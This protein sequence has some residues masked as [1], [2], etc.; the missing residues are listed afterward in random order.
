MYCPHCKANYD[1]YSQTTDMFFAPK[2]CPKCG[3]FLNGKT[4][5]QMN[6][7]F[8]EKVTRYSNCIVEILENDQGDVSVGWYKTKETEEI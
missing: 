1:A 8:Y 2:Y 6:M 4:N 5:I 7:A 3:I